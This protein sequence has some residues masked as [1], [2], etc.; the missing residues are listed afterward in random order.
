M[1]NA[2][3]CLV[4]A[5]TQGSSIDSDLR[6]LTGSCAQKDPTW[7]DCSMVTLL[8]FLIPFEQGPLHFHFA[9]GTSGYV[10]AS[11][12]VHSLGMGF[13]IPINCS[14]SQSCPPHPPFRNT[15]SPPLPTPMLFFPT[16]DL[17]PRDWERCRHTG[18]QLAV[19]SLLPF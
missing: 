16:G 7:V 6:R 19:S 14:S 3:A 8:K 12:S 17:S 18:S 9:S 15:S 4:V 10:V 11:G 13:V 5:Y 2:L 1:E